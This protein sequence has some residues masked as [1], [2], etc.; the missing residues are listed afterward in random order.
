VLLV[1]TNGTFSSFDA[2]PFEFERGANMFVVS[3]SDKKLFLL[4][5]SFHRRRTDDI[6]VNRKIGGAFIIDFSDS[7]PSAQRYLESDSTNWANFWRDA[8]LVGPSALEL[9]ILCSS[10]SKWI[11]KQLNLHIQGEQCNI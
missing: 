6:L 4:V 9:S 2:M 5:S 8:N 1:D 11:L 10:K 3:A 7:Q